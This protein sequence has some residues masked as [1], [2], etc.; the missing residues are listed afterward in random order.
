[1]QLITCWLGTAKIYGA[2]EMRSKVNACVEIGNNR[3]IIFKFESIW[4][5]RNINLLTQ[6]TMTNVHL[7]KHSRDLIYFAGVRPSGIN[8]NCCFNKFT[9]RKRHASDSRAIFINRHNFFFES[10]L[11][12]EHFCGVNQIMSSQH[13]VI[14]E[15][16]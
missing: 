15:T 9:R 10:S 16:T 7:V 12:S 1:M 3:N 6:W 4:R 13:W 14:H 2:T 8:N 5:R 11:R